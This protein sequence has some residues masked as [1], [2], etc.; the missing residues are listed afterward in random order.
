M[1]RT[2]T[3][4]WY[5]E[6]RLSSIQPNYLCGRALVLWWEGCGFKTPT[7]GNFFKEFGLFCHL[8]KYRSNEA[9]ILCAH[10][11]QELCQGRI[12]SRQ[13]VVLLHF[14]CAKPSLCHWLSLKGL[15]WLIYLIARRPYYRPAALSQ[16]SDSRA[17]CLLLP[18]H[19]RSLP[20]RRY[21]L[22]D[23]ISYL[24]DLSISATASRKAIVFYHTKTQ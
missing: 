24:F 14:Q 9:I 6:V 16:T 22:V 10:Y 4:W 12:K 8:Y 19:D 7:V 1:R 11:S 5:S 3:G 21:I 15:L 17:Q 2:R 20:I 13:P 23:F 18:N